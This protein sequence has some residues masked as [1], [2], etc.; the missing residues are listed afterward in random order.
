MRSK[1]DSNDSKVIVDVTL[2]GMTGTRKSAKERETMGWQIGLIGLAFSWFGWRNDAGWLIVS[3]LVVAVIG[4]IMWG[5]GM[6]HG[7]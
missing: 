6:A 7:D 5:A 2:R 1:F 3:G 4:G